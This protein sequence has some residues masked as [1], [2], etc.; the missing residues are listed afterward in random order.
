MA[1]QALGD[2]PQAAGQFA[3]LEG[4]HFVE[5]PAC[6]QGVDEGAVEE[7]HREAAVL[8]DVVAVSDACVV[9]GVA[10]VADGVDERAP[11]A[12]DAAD[13]ADQDVDLLGGQRHAQQHVCEDRVDGGIRQRERVAYV[14]HRG[15]HL[16]GDSL[17]MS[18]FSQLVQSGGAEVDGLDGE[19]A[20]SEVQGVTPVSGTQLQD[21]GGT[22]SS[23]WVKK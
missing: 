8:E 9:V 18:G 7:V 14:V 15:G 1:G 16:L 20:L 2:P 21:V 12:Q 13:F 19:A 23:H 17:R 5:G 10:G 11:G 6:G 22:G 4:V 3:L